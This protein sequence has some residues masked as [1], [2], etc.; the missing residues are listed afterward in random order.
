MAH[1]LTIRKAT[2]ADAPTLTTLAHDA[3]R[4]WGYPEH[5]IKHWQ[6]DLTISPEFVDNNLVYVAEADAALIGFYA[7]IIR[8]DKAEL[9]HLWVAPAHLGSGIGKTLFLHAMQN[10]ARRDV[11]A[12]GISSDPNAEG[13]YRKL[14]AYRTGETVSE[15]D[16]EPRSVPRL[17][18]DPKSKL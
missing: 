8:G 3:K 9:D 1:S 7:L 4:H 5:W 10:A 11:S 15:I 12:V 2:T 17:S 13:F 14:G 18:V 6:D 16:G